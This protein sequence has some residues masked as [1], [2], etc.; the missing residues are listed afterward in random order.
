MSHIYRF[1][2]SNVTLQ[3]SKLVCQ[4]VSIFLL[5]I[6]IIKSRPVGVEI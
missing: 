1:W 6:I 3:F 5:I 2:G 4:Y